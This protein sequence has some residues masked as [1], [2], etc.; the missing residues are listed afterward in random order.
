MSAEIQ[1]QIDVQR[2]EE[3]RRRYVDRELPD[4]PDY[5]DGFDLGWDAE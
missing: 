2:E 5:D 3:R 1:K 4:L